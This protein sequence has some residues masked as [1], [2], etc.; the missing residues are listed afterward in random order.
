MATKSISSPSRRTV[1]GSQVPGA[2][3][4]QIHKSVQQ[5]NYSAAG[6][7]NKMPKR[8]ALMT[9]CAILGLAFHSIL[10][11]APAFAEFVC[12]STIPG[13]S[14]GAN[15]SGGAPNFNV[16][17]GT[18]ANASGTNSL[19]TAIGRDSNSSGSFSRNTALGQAANAT[20][21]NSVNTATGAVADAH[22]TG[23]QNIATG[24]FA[25]ASGSTNTPSNESCRRASRAS[26]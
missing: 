9:G 26:T 3:S 20:G 17:C 15:A 8:A 14:D 5:Q 10:F 12:D 18:N 19:N 22:G 25:N 24:F 11:P 4:C 23:S 2:I 16:A 6:L 7:G 1:S 13:G 21:D